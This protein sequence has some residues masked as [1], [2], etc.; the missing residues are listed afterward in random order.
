MYVLHELMF[1]VVCGFECFYDFKY[2]VM[3]MFI[4]MNEYTICFKDSCCWISSCDLISL[5]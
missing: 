5:I 3:F 2:V 4:C 1:R